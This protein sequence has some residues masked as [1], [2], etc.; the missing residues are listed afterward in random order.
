[1]VHGEADTTVPPGH[2]TVK[3]RL[4]RPDTQVKAPDVAAET[5]KDPTI[6]K[7]NPMGDAGLVE[8]LKDMLSRYDFAGML[9]AV[10]DSP[11][12]DSPAGKK[13]IERY[14][15][16]N[17]FMSWFGEQISTTD[18]DHAM[19]LGIDPVHNGATC[20]FYGTTSGY[21]EVKTASSAAEKP[22]SQLPAVELVSFA[23]VMM[24]FP[25]ATEVIS[26]NELLEDGKLLLAEPEVLSGG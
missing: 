6:D 15:R 18:A 5:K 4:Q 2:G 7:L 9:K 11:Y 23:S 13:M 24:D 21:V 17:A 10:S 26:R 16:L 1:M 22:I 19:T 12:A 20:T 25:G 3:P 14:S 8:K